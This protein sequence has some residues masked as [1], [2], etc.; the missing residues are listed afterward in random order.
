[1]ESGPRAGKRPDNTPFAAIKYVSSSFGA[2]SRPPRGKSA[3]WLDIYVSSG[4]EV[5]G[6]YITRPSCNPPLHGFLS[7][8]DG[9]LLYGTD[10]VNGS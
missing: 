9:I 2:F 1:M 5:G 6:V 10:K 4:Q 3:F 8:E 7:Y